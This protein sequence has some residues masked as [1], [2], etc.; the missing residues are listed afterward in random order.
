M[1]FYRKLEVAA[2][3]RSIIERIAEYEL[4]EKEN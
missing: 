2:E 1:E 4:Y 3:N